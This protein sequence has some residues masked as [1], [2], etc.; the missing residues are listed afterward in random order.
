MSNTTTNN[1]N[2]AAEMAWLYGIDFSSATFQQV[3]AWAA[4]RKNSERFAIKRTFINFDQLA[5]VEVT[6]SECFHDLE[7]SKWMGKPVYGQR[8]NTYKFTNY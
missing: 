3:E 4:G 1:T 7:T 8:H 2:T 5:E 6:V